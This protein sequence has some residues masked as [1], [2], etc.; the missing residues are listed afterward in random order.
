[1]HE[2]KV[3]VVDDEPA[4]REVLSMRIEGWGYAVRTAA[5]VADAER[6][7][8]R[9]KPD[10]VISDVVMPE[11]TGLELLK[12][13]KSE[14]ASRPV[15]LVTAHGSIDAAVEAMKEGAQDFLTKPLDYT[16]LHVLLE[17]T[18]ADLRRRGELRQI[19]TSL[20]EEG[21]PGLLIGRSA[22]MR[23][24]YATLEMLAAS[25]ASALITGESGTGKEVV[26]RTI[27]ELSDRRGGPFVAVNSAAIPEGLIE[28]ELFGHE[29]GAFTGAVRTRPGCFEQAD[30]GTLFLDEIA[31]MPLSLQPKL[32]RILEDGSVRRLGG[33]KEI[34]FDVRVLAATNRPAAAAVEEAYLREDLFYR[35]N[36][37]ELTVPPLRERIDDLALLAQHFLR[38]FSGK[39]QME[40]TGLR[41]E[42]RELLEAY[43][44]PGN[45]RELR[46]VLER[47]V[48]VARSGW[49]ETSHLPPYFRSQR[50]ARPMLTVPL[51]T[52]AAEAEKALILRTLEHVGHN[53]AE[54]ARRLG[55]D[56]KTIRNKLKTYGVHA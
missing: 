11:T 35:L 32:L 39:H 5:D 34:E 29:R 31:E 55:L 30:G 44:W 4:L 49:I 54:A 10:I 40:I 48:I 27:H 38:E 42:A 7:L 56:V 28:S 33:N 51:G 45:V 16:K 19:E 52:S 43:S 6:L 37:F 53:K 3:L 50:N 13:L 36:V 2:L 24:L 23:E 1:M 17:T 9:E 26:A 22:P 46:N 15:I 8:Q 21:A 20:A 25:D 47:A 14:D 12:R 18:A 41:D